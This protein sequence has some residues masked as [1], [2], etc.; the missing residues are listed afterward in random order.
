K[1][2]VARGYQRIAFIGYSNAYGEGWYEEF[3]KAAGLKKLELVANERF[4]PNDT[5]ATAQALKLVAAKPDA[6]LIAASG[7]P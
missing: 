2:M 4:A 3:K 1:D 7:T 6:I 5:S